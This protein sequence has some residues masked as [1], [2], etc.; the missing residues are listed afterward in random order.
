MTTSKIKKIH[1]RL[2]GVVVSAKADKTRVVEVTRVISH[3]KYGKRYRVSKRFSAHDPAN[4]YKL[5]DKVLIEETR[6][7]SKTKRWRI[8]AKISE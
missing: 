1:R 2:S 5:G 6:P 8:V 4:T 7:I 3:V